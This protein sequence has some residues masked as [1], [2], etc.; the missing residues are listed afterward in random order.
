MARDCAE[1]GI[2]LLASTRDHG[3]TDREEGE[4]GRATAIKSGLLESLI[5]RN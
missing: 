1:C 3:F 2:G 4:L 5:R